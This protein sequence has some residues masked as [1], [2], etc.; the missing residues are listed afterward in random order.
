VVIRGSWVM[1]RGWL[2]DGPDSG[3]GSMVVREWLSYGLGWLSG[4][5][6]VARGWSGGDLVMVRWWLGSNSGLAW[7][8]SA[9][10]SVVV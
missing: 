3:V 8:W 2:G 1:V 4:D 7:C 10:G 5:L 6:G 9:G